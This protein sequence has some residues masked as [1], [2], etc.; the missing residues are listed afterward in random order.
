VD[1]RGRGTIGPA[2]K[3]WTTVL[4]S[5]KFLLVRPEAV[6]VRPASR[7]R[8]AHDARPDRRYPAN[9][10]PE[11][12]PEVFTVLDV[13]RNSLGAGP[14]EYIL[15]LDNQKSSNKGHAPAGRATG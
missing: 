1:G 12:P 13:A 8:G 10:V 7:D 5:F 11:T 4:N 14:C 9:R 15:D 2:R 3:R 6:G